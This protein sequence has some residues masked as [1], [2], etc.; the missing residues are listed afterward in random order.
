M[1][2]R[3]ATGKQLAEM[4][5]YPCVRLSDVGNCSWNEHSIAG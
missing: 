3:V 1:G 4:I 5:V 2:G